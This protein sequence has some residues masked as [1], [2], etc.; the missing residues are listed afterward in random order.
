[1]PSLPSGTSILSVLTISTTTFPS[2]EIAFIPLYL[3][4]D[5]IA[6]LNNAFAFSKSLHATCNIGDCD[7]SHISL[8]FV[9][10]S[11]HF[12]FIAASTSSFVTER[13]HLPINFASRFA[14]ISGI[15]I[16]TILPEQLLMVKK[17]SK[18]FI[19]FIIGAISSSAPLIRNLTSALSF[20]AS[21]VNAKDSLVLSIFSSSLPQITI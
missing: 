8:P 7:N 14:P 1:M 9:I 10:S 16:K 4:P 19:L 5:S 6:I 18:L 11:R 13:C 20:C 17:S 21:N 12:S 3:N 2:F 15:E